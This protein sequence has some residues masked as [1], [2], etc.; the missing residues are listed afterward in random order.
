[1]KALVLALLLAFSFPANAHEIKVGDLIIVHPMVAEAEKGQAS[2]KGTVKIRN[3]GKTPD[4]LLS[5]SAEFAEKAVI[6]APVPVPVPANGQA[7][8]IPITYE[9]IKR[10]LSEDEAYASEFVF[11]K[12]GTMKVDLMVHTHAH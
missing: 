6:D 5:I 3:N 9:I 12:A 2:A 1:M 8:S 7:V 10:K 11:E 4:H